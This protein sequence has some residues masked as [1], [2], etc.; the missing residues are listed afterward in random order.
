[1]K[2]GIIVYC[3]VFLVLCALKVSLGQNYQLV[4]SDEFIGREVD[5]NI[6]T[7]ETGGHGWGNEELQYYTGRDTN[8]Y[9]QDGKLI[10]QALK[11]NYGAK[12]YTSARLITQDKKSFNY[13]KIESRMKLPYGKGIWPAFWML[14]QN[15]SSVGWPACGEIDIMEMIGGINNDNRV[16]GTIHWENNG[17]H[18]DYG[19]NYSLPSGIFAEDFHLFSIEWTP[20]FVRWF[21]DG[22]Q[23]H[24]VDITPSELSE[25]HQNFFIIL[26]IAVGGTWPG[27]PDTS[28]VFP[29]QFEIDYIRVYQDVSSIPEVTLTVPNNN[30]EYNENDDILIAA[31]VEYD[32]EI[33]KVE[34][35]QDELKIGETEIEPY[36]M[37]WRNVSSGNYKIRA[38]AKSPDGFTGESEISN[39]IVGGGAEKFPYKGSPNNIPGIIE[40]EDFDA[41]GN[42]IGYSDNTI[43]NVGQTYRI[44]ESVD[45]EICYDDNGGYNIGWTEEGEW[46]N[47]TINVAR[48]A[49]YE[50]TT[51]VATEN[52]GGAFLIEVD[53]VVLTESIIVPNTGSWQDWTSV[54]TSV[55]LTEGIHDFKVLLEGNEFNI[56]RFEIYEPNTDP[57]LI[58]L[59]PNGGETLLIGSIQ[60]V[61]WNQLKVDEVSIGLSIDGGNNWSFVG[62]NIASKYGSYRWHVPDSQSE[63]CIIMII[64]SKASSINDVTDSVFTID[65][66]NSVG[67]ENGVPSG[68]FLTQNYPNPFNPETIIGFGIPKRS[69]VNIKLYD[70]LGREIKVLV[71]EVISAGNFQYKLNGTDLSSGVYYYRIQADDYTDA[72]KLL[73][74]K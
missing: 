56:N 48:S 7:Y 42:N 41:G 33:E 67:P 20:Q 39:I 21:I 29:Q 72:K 58:L 38:V 73:L 54:T 51:R 6:W 26:N 8:A 46:I 55:E 2:K 17:Q 18:A 71:D 47:Y 32:S 50:L 19:G 65:Y 61:Q 28:T 4:W 10:I 15:F 40:A 22:W 69:N 62:K 37:N 66:V 49:G 59:Q 36:E 12:N 3:L 63:N 43:Q 14:G 25:F 27:S 68:Y 23:F 60:E 34:F 5:K 13:G 24:I 74:I 57:Q 9:I 35:Y 16:Y 1:M 30:V 11:E 31:G 53:G 52:S 64:D 45:I 44:N 70:Q